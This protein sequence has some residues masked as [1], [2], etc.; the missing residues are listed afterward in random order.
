ML[1]ETILVAALSSTDINTDSLERYY[2]DCDTLYM[3]QELGGQDMNTCLTLT[4]RFIQDR[5]DNDMQL[6]WDYWA[7]NRL[8]QWR[9]RGYNGPNGSQGPKKIAA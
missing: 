2:W 7:R 3:K 8:T 6:F 4:R 1:L 5:F 9:Q